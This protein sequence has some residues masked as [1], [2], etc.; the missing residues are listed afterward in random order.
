MSYSALSHELM[1]DI[2]IPMKPLLRIALPV[3]LFLFF[4][5]Y[6]VGATQCFDSTVEETVAGAHT[7]VIGS[8][9]AVDDSVLIRSGNTVGM[10]EK[11]VPHRLEIERVYKGKAAPSLTVY[12]RWTIG[13]P[14]LRLGDNW[15]L[16][17]HVDKSGHLTAGPC[18]PSIK[19]APGSEPPL[20]LAVV[21]GEGRAPN[22]IIWMPQGQM[23]ATGIGLVGAGLYLLLR[24]KLQGHR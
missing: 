2:D 6:P 20:E 22:E 19:L 9:I 17:L 14:P 16:F 15:L 12:Q 23:A 24:L 11:G 18:D 8:V 7:I 1:G 5:A 3:C 4:A 21:L 13:A 10:P